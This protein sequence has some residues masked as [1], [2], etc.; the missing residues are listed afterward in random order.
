MMT[1]AALVALLMAAVETISVM[2]PALVFFTV[3]TAAVLIVMMVTAFLSF[4]MM[5]ARMPFA[6]MMPVVV[7][8]GIGVIFQ[9]S[10]NKSFYS[11]ISSALNPCIK[12]DPGI[13]KCRL[14]THANASANQ[15][16]RL[17]RLQESCKCSVA[18]AVGRYDL[19][20]YDPAL[21][22]V[23]QLKLLGMAKVLEDLSVFI[24]DCDSHT[25]VSFLHNGLLQ[26]NRFK[27]A[28]AACDQQPLPADEGVR[29]LP[30]GAVV[31]GR[32][33]GPGDVHPGGAGFLREAF[34]IQKS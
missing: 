22:N 31:D 10:F 32:D 18:A 2:M 29:H 34:I 1:A 17:N 9:R 15:S 21:R 24:G 16:I 19:F 28:S 4:T 26:F 8:A 20:V 14:R 25:V 3:M 5:P 27:G 33:G 12:L 23:V 11:S 30:P 6:V 13:G 7:T